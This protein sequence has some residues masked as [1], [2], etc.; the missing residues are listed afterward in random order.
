MHIFYGAQFIRTS[1][2]GQSISQI[3]TRDQGTCV[4]MFNEGF[5]TIP[6]V[7]G[8]IALRIVPRIHYALNDILH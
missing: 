5:N 4:F 3:N 7:K 6:K 2:G 1:G 8:L